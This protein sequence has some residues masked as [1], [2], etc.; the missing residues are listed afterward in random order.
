[1]FNLDWIVAFPSFQTMLY[2]RGSEKEDVPKRAAEINLAT[3]GVDNILLAMI[4][5]IR[6][7]DKGNLRANSNEPGLS[8]RMSLNSITAKVLWKMVSC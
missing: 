6:E 1:M 4:F 2:N 5:S 3:G 8:R 7:H